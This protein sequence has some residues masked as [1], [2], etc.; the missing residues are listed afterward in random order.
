MLCAFPQFVDSFTPADMRRAYGLDVRLR[1][2]KASQASLRSRLDELIWATH[3]G[4][5]KVDAEEF[6]DFDTKLKLKYQYHGVSPSRFV[7]FYVH[8]SFFFKKEIPH[9]IFFEIVHFS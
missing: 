9:T 2:A 1:A 8:F 5:E 6:Q 7:R 4:K 3:G